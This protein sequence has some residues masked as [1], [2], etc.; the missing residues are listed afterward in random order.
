[1]KSLKIRLSIILALA[2]TFLAA[3]GAFFGTGMFASADRDTTVDGSS[4]TLFNAS[5][6]ADLRAHEQ[7]GEGEEKEYYT[8]FA[9]KEKDG[10]IS[11]KKNLAYWWYSNTATTTE[12]EGEGEGAVEKTVEDLKNPTRSEKSFFNMEVGFENLN[13]ERY[14]IKF[15]SQQYYKTKDEKTSNYV[16]FVPSKTEEN[17]VNV[18][19][20]DN[21]DEKN[22]TADT[23]FNKD[24]IKIEFTGTTENGYSPPVIGFTDNVS[25][26]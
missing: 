9:I 24:K 10:V 22:L 5:A 4:T 26:G 13:F 23:A 25:V 20:T 14:I 17:K 15:E 12:T 11:Y 7:D 1:M 16:I 3:V 2:V 21:K 6:G 18:I 19:I 8:M